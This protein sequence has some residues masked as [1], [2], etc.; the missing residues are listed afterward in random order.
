M[1]VRTAGE[2]ENRRVP[3]VI[4]P[5]QG[6]QLKEPEAQPPLG[7]PYHASAQPLVPG[8]E[9]V[10][11]AALERQTN[12]LVTAFQDDGVPGDGMSGG[13]AKGGGAHGGAD[14]GTRLV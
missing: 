6:S 13:I 7:H 5:L 3:A 2:N 11:Q 4:D 8:G 9:A 1:N 14:G 10:L 12:V